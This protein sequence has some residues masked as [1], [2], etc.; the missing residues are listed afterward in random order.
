MFSSTDMLHDNSLALCTQGAQEQLV[1]P[2]LLKPSFSSAAS[3]DQWQHW[4]A[5]VAAAA[6]AAWVAYTGCLLNRTEGP[7]LLASL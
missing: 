3:R 6:A 2:A 7:V 5:A 1:M 4:A